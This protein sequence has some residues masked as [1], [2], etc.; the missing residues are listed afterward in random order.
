MSDTMTQVDYVLGPDGYDPTK[1]EVTTGF[2]ADDFDYD[3]LQQRIAEGNAR[4][5]ILPDASGRLHEMTIFNAGQAKSVLK[6]STSYSGLLKNPANFL[7]NAVLA[8]LNPDTE[9]RYWT[10]FGNYP[11]GHLSKEDRHYQRA[12]GRYTK[13]DGSEENPYE[14]ID[15]IKYLVEL[16]HKTDLLPD[17][18]MADQEAGRL[19]LGIMAELPENSVK[20]AYLNAIDGLSVHAHYLKDDFVPDMASRLKR[21]RIHDSS[22]EELTPNNIKNVKKAAPTIYHG[23]FKVLH[24]PPF[25]WLPLDLR[26]KISYE[27]GR[28]KHKDLDDL[29]DHAVY[30]D[31]SAAHRRQDAMITIRLNKS[32]GQDVEECLQFGQAIMEHIPT[33]LQSQNRGIRFIIGDETKTGN[34][35]S[36]LESASAARQAIS[37]PEDRRRQMIAL[38]SRLSLSQVFDMPS[39]RQVA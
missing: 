26:D 1:G 35:D 10:S 28:S 20:G 21:R 34:T 19:A 8:T 30:Q 29:E 2:S 15:S 39:I 38:P 14:A 18:F 16:L 22:P 4:Y 7:E 32:G 31:M 5:M 23:P 12:E 37:S 17:Y 36:P 11:T 13:G 33:G 24:L 6:P 25:V 27:R 9:L 3:G